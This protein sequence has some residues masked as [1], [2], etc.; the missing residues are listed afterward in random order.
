MIKVLVSDDNKR[1]FEPWSEK[2]VRFDIDLKCFSNWEEAQYE[3][4]NNWDVYEFIILDGKGKIQEE[5]VEANQKHLITAVQWLKVQFGNGRY[6]PIVIYTGFYELIEGI[7]IKDAQ[8]LEI[9]DKDKNEIDEVFNFILKVVNNNP[10]RE[11]RAQ[12]PDIFE[13]FD[14]GFLSKAMKNE[15]IEICKELKKDN[16]AQYKST[17]RRMRP[18]IE[19][20]LNQLKNADGNLIPKAL[21]KTGVPETSGIIFHL[22]GKPRFNRD[23]R[24]MEYYAE[25][26]LPEHVYYLIN[27]LYDTTSKVAMHDYDQKITKYLVKSCLFGLLEFLIWFKDFYTKNYI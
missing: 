3:L 10:E 9:F 19:N 21:F 22:A 1:L 12:F 17:L 7:T 4:D 2:A 23:K 24:E 25:K 20:V 8:I 6:K 16:P 26:V 14:S 5:G 18:L 13:V 11:A 27:T 15:F